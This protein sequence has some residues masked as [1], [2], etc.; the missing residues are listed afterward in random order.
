MAHVTIENTPSFVKYSVTTLDDGPFNVPFAIFTDDGADLV[1]EVDGEDIGAAF[2]YTTTSTTTGG[3]QT[4]EVTLDV[5]VANAEVLIYRR[6]T[7]ARTSD[8][9]TGPLPRDAVNSEFDKVQAQIA[10]LRRDL[11]L[12]ARAHVGGSVD[13]TAPASGANYLGINAA[14]N[15]VQ[16]SSAAMAFAL[17]TS[18]EPILTTAPGS[19][20]EEM[21]GKAAFSRTLESFDCAGDGVTDD[22]VNARAAFN[23]GYQ[24]LGGGPGKTY[25]ISA[26]LVSNASA[27]ML[28]SDG[29]GATF[30][31][32][33]GSGG[34]NVTT[35]ATRDTTTVVFNPKDP[36]RCRFVNWRFTGDGTKEVV[37]YLFRVQRPPA[38]FEIHI[39]DEDF[40][41][42]G[43]SVVVNSALKGSGTVWVRATGG[44]I[45]QGNTHWTGTPQKTAHETDNDIDTGE[46]SYPYNVLYC[47][48]DFEFTGDAL[49]H[50][51]NETDAYTDARIGATRP[52]PHVF[53]IVARNTGEGADLMGYGT[54]IGLLM[55][56]GCDRDVKFI[57]SCRAAC[58]TRIV[59]K[60]AGQCIVKFEGASTTP[61]T[62]VD[63]ERNVVGWI[64]GDNPV[65][66][67]LFG[68]GADSKPRNNYVLGGL[69]KCGAA[70]TSIISD[71][72]GA[73]SPEG[74]NHIIDLDYVGTPA[75][76]FRYM[77]GAAPTNTYVR[78]GKTE[79]ARLYLA[80]DVSVATAT[81]IP[82]VPY[83]TSIDRGGLHAPVAITSVSRTSNVVTATATAHGL[84]VGD[85]FCVSG[86]TDTSFNGYGFTVASAP[87]ANTITYAQTASNA[88]S[89]GGNI[90]GGAI[91]WKRPG[92]KRCTIMHTWEPAAVDVAFRCVVRDMAGTILRNIYVPASG[93]NQLTGAPIPFYID[94]DPFDAGDHSRAGSGFLVSV[95][96][97]GA[98][99]QALKDGIT[100]T[101]L[102]VERA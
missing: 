53:T 67:V 72:M 14:R 56:E 68:S 55:T 8:Y 101:W 59:S 31:I 66:A 61:D 50:F 41:H 4:G 48:A 21:L 98:G 95:E 46:W 7:P 77:A 6:I 35:V 24:I 13:L 5:A 94:V 30:K 102:E 92:L 40:A 34:F 33:T 58:V 83:A 84:A 73:L 17:Q 26:Y 71:G 63:T 78:G 87:D 60:N 69:I 3:N 36:T 19:G 20:W 42:A 64:E 39:R 65:T 29:R 89:S 16:L 90:N 76:S 15:I 57:H 62:L 2:S 51:G 27:I 99:T 1:V 54:T 10:D 32:K 88:T 43:V 11:D 85:R 86:V 25:L 96:H 75:A 74:N 45:T 9:G 22:T 38:G 44:N 47:E 79:F 52:G 91:I 93:D 100:R 80:A 82:V 23:S 28:D 37:C 49:S 81:S 12:A 97:D 70:T 18:W